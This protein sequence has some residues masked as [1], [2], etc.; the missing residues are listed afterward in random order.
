[1]SEQA[2]PIAARLGPRGDELAALMEEARLQAGGICAL[3]IDA[4][5]CQFG[6]Y[7]GRR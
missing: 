3:W 1:M 2:R 4:R 7:S 5:E 6:A